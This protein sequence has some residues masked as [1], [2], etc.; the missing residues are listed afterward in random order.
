M[1]LNK[2]TFQDIAQPYLNPRF[3][4][5]FIDNGL[6]M[7]NS[8]ISNVST[9]NGQIPIFGNSDPNPVNIIYKPG[10]ITPPDTNI[11]TTWNA[12]VLKSN[13]LNVNGTLNI[14]FDDSVAPCVIDQSLDCNC[15]TNFYPACSIAEGLGATN[16]VTISEFVQVFNLRAIIGPLIVKSASTIYN[17]FSFTKQGIVFRLL[18]G[19]ALQLQAGATKEFIEVKNSS[20]SLFLQHGSIIDNSLNSSLA[21]VNL[22]NS[23][24]VLL[25]FTIPSISN[26]SIKG[27]ITS[28][29]NIIYDSSYNTTTTYS[30]FLGTL[31]KSPISNAIGTF[32]DD[33][34]VLPSIS[35]DNSQ[36]AIDT[37]KSTYLPLSGGTVTG[38]LK[39]SQ[40]NYFI[41]AS[42]NQTISFNTYSKLTFW[43]TIISS[44]DITY[45]SGDFK[46]NTAGTYQIICNLQG[47]ASNNPLVTFICVNNTSMYSFCVN[48]TNGLGT[49]GFTMSKIVKLAINDVINTYA[50]NFGL[51]N[52][53]TTVGPKVI[54]GGIPSPIV[55]TSI[56]SIEI[57]MI[58]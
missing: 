56:C 6:D 37:I 3:N 49:S 57:M 18:D 30:T 52:T 35:S 45:G 22:I 34:K 23:I 48:T 53:D 43:D 19:A 41:T 39:L 7:N 25:V 17:A 5:L 58:G 15:I 51:I 36:S 40:P 10:S 50:G 16:T 8:G 47:D 4:S 33:T 2:F 26:D 29:L 31:N 11:L 42:A 1:S 20:I 28:V 14:Y 21:C 54:G 44:S 24:L 55:N 46:I 9:I 12:V 32:Y 27:D 38:T 13:Q